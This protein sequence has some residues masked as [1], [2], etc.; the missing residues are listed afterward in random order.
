MKQLQMGYTVWASSLLLRWKMALPISLVV[1]VLYASG[2]LVAGA[3]VRLTTLLLMNLNPIPW[4]GAIGVIAYYFLKYDRYMAD[5]G[6]D[7]NW[8]KWKVWTFVAGILMTMFL[9][10]SPLNA[11]V[12]ESMTL[13]TLKLMGEFELAAPLIVFGI[14]FKLIDHEKMNG[15]FWKLLRFMHHPSVTAVILAVILVIWDMSD[16]MSL[17]LKSP[18]VFALLPGVYLVSG[19]IVW[20]QSLQV[21]PSW[22]NLRN[23]LQKALYVWI[24]EMAMMGM[25]GIWFWSA[26]SMNPAQSSHML[27]G[28]T[29]LFDEHLAGMMMTFLSLPTMCLVTWHF[30]QWMEGVL[31]HHS[32]QSEYT[33]N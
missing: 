20:M 6:S 30:W 28:L 5:Q 27:W 16:Q 14:P 10:E 22:P 4:L 33:V 17:G 21:F 24:M 26:M 8:S 23:H 3:P 15:A 18:L 31:E 25:G 29:P 32:D 12:P 1:I 13:Y 2:Y 7:A 19:I 9:W 11:F